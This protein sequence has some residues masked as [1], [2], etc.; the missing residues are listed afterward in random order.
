MQYPS[1]RSST[2]DWPRCQSVKRQGPVVAGM[3]VKS[4]LAI[5]DAGKNM[6]E[7]K[8]DMVASSSGYGLE[9]TIWNVR[10]SCMWVGERAKCHWRVHR[11][12]RRDA[13]EIWM[14]RW[15]FTGVPRPRSEWRAVHTTDTPGA[16]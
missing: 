9:C 5:N 13:G 7:K 16:A 2:N 15:M 10:L 4:P 3:P 11:R 14:S 1:L 8:C 12:V 6:A